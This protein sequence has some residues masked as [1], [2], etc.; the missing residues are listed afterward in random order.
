MVSGSNEAQVLDVS[1][2]DEFNERQSDRYE[3]DL[4][5]YREKQ[6]SQTECGPSQRA[7]AAMKRGMVSYYRLGN[8]IC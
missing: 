5:R 3:V 8:F 4:F 7:K 2:Q 6:T 1:S